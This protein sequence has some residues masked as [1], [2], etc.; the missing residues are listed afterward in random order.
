MTAKG[1]VCHVLFQACLQGDAKIDTSCAAPCAH[2]YDAVSDPQKI[3][4]K[5]IRTC[6][7]SSEEHRSHSCLKDAHI[8]VFIL[9]YCLCYVLRIFCCPLFTHWKFE[10]EWPGKALHIYEQGFEIRI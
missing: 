7:L 6:H 1:H 8:S 9:F 5:E 2:P 3:E 4:N 10:C